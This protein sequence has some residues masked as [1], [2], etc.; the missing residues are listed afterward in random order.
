VGQ[1]AQLDLRVVG[2]DE[3]VTGLGDEARADLAAE[4]GADRD[5]LKVRVG[6]RQPAGR[7]RGLVEGGVQAA[8]LR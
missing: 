3:L 4:L 2:A 7:R 1:D 6:G 8:G 5:V